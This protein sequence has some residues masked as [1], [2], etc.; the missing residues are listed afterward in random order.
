M[1]LP[2]RNG[3]RA[4]VQLDCSTHRYPGADR[5]SARRLGTLS[6][7]VAMNRESAAEVGH[8]RAT[9]RARNSPAGMRQTARELRV[10]A[11]TASDSCDRTAM[12]SLAAEFESRADKLERRF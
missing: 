1:G 7:R 11:D 5:V 2:P 4:D 3:S 10:R 8:R 12:L 6:R 9:E